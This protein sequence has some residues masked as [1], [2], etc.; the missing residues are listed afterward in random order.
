MDYVIVFYFLG[1][2]VIALGAWVGRKGP[3]ISAL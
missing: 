1:F 3:G 2:G